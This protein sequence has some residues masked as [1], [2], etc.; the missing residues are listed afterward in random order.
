[1]LNLAPVMNQQEPTHEAAPKAPEG[2]VPWAQVRRPQIGLGSILKRIKSIDINTVEPAEEL[3]MYERSVV[4][5]IFQFDNLNIS[6][7][8]N[9]I[10]TRVLRSNSQDRRIY[11]VMLHC[12]RRL[13]WQD[14]RGWSGWRDLMLHDSD[15]WKGRVLFHL[16]DFWRWPVRPSAP[17]LLNEV[18]TLMNHGTLGI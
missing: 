7:L 9:I 5:L 1:M 8:V 2:G 6:P 14:A 17:T 16:Q 4:N 15:I 11:L 18:K 13:S 10:S 3:H 12:C